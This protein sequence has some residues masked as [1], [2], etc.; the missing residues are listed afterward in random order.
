[1]AAWRIP[2]NAEIHLR[3]HRTGGHQNGGVAAIGR[4]LLLAAQCRAVVAGTTWSEVD[5][6]EREW[7]IPRERGKNDRPHEV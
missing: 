5:L 7:T 3:S 2:P 4:L 1:M 6:G